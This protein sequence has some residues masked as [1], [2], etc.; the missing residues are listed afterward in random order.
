MK[1]SVECILFFLIMKENVIQFQNEIQLF[2][3][4]TIINIVHSVI[5]GWFSC[6]RNLGILNFR[7]Q[8]WHTQNKNKICIFSQIE[9]KTLEKMAKNPQKRPK[10]A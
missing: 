10:M 9:S 3:K 2:S 1:H 7:S 8:K 6:H 4:M 5:Q